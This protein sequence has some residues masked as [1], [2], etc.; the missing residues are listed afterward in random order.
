MK[1]VFPNSV[2]ST[3][4]ACQRIL[5]PLSALVL[6]DKVL[7]VHLGIQDYLYFVIKVTFIVGPTESLRERSGHNVLFN[8]ARRWQEGE[9]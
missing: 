2:K 4:L 9:F 8:Q 1:D 7:V 5:L 3:L 6:E